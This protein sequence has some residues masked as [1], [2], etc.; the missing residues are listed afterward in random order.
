MNFIFESLKIRIQFSLVATFVKA[1]EGQGQGS[2]MTVSTVLKRII[3]GRNSEIQETGR[4]LFRS[5]LKASF[6]SHIGGVAEEDII[7]R[8]GDSRILRLF[9]RKTLEF[10]RVRNPYKTKIWVILSRLALK[11]MAFSI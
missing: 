1:L 2:D 7:T 8:L 5:I 6:L 3:S 10:F 11:V 9:L 4:K